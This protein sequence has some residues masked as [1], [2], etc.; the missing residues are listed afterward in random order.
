MPGVD[1]RRWRR[2]RERAA[3]Y[4]ASFEYLAPTSLDEAVSILE[5]YEDEAKVLAGGQSLI[6][7]MKLRFAAPRGARRH[8]PHRGPR[9][10]RR[11]ERRA[12]RSAPS[13]ATRRASA[14][15]LLGGRYGVLG[16]AAPQ[17]SDPIVR[18][19]GTVVRVAGARRPAGRLGLGAARRSAPR[20]SRRGPDGDA[21]DP[22]RRALP[23]ARSRRRS[24]P[25]EIVDRGPRPRPGRRAGGTYLKL[26]RKVGDFATVGVAV[27][28]T[29][30]ERQRRAGR[31]RAHRRRPD[32]TSGPREAEEA[33]AGAR[34]RPTRR[35]TRRPAGRRG[36]GAARRH[37]RHRRVQAQRRAG[38]H[39]A[40]PADGSRSG[41]APRE[42]RS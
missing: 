29:L 8:Q 22:D 19:L 2:P 21:H 11:G 41:A 14:P 7:L 5:R 1:R 39:R 13:C 15:T 20:W 26:E 18:N 35:S 10:A 9:H 40:R 28:V 4:P 31:H 37:P 30:D 25:T 27:H 3:V 24:S 42:E 34:A 32:A 38:V 23:R 17:I 12:A 33:L 36:R 16:D 6:P